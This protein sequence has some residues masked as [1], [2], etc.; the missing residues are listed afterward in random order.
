MPT[1]R[2]W[3]KI[4][5][6]LL[7]NPVVCKDSDHIAVW[8][9][10]LLNAAHSEQTA[11]FGGEKITLLPGQ[12]LTSKRAIAKA[13]KID[14][15]K[16]YRILKRYEIE[17]QIEPRTDRQQSLITIRNWHYYQSDNEPRNEP[18]MNHE[19]TTEQENKDE[20]EKRNKKEKEENKE[21][22]KNGRS[23]NARACEDNNDKED[24]F[25]FF[26]VGKHQNI[27]VSLDWIADFKLNYSYATDVI[28]SFSRY[29]RD[30]N[31]VVTNDMEILEEAAESFDDWNDS[32]IAY[33]H[34]EG[35]LNGE[36][37]STEIRIF[38]W[39]NTRVLMLSER[40]FDSICENC[41]L[42]EIDYYMDRMVELV[43]K[44]YKFNC[45]H[46]EY[47]MKMVE[48]DRRVRN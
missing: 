31:I 20:K 1:D 41:G 26:V 6:K 11:M 44:G 30:T 8:F 40:Q 21:S 10:L 4:H 17:L 42:H 34:L 38:A 48:K 47:I 18:R 37:Q 32:K 29:K 33:E 46:Y 5:R 3:V 14:P 36:I 43:S 24:S 13:L 9:F 25:D 2:G 12:L 7:N 15:S 16:V 22:S 35:L 23:S 45:S 28:D 19:R 39:K 27:T